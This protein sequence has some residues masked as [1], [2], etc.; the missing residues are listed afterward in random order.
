MYNYVAVYV[1]LCVHVC[2]CVCVCVLC[3]HVFVC[4]CMC[5]C[6]C[7][8][9]CVVCACVCVCVCMVCVCLCVCVH[10]FVCVVCTLW[11]PC[12][13][14]AYVHLMMTYINVLLWSIQL[15]VLWWHA[16]TVYCK[17]FKVEE[18]CNFRRLISKHKT[19]PVN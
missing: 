4:V 2:V 12:N 7:A 14:I 18:F 5:L 1:C 3:V 19:L 10:V 17:S 6:L 13:N 11:W 9:V 15:T 16:Y 8:C